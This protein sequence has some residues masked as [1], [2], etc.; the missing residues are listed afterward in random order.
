MIFEQTTDGAVDVITHYTVYYCLKLKMRVV[1]S[2]LECLYY[3]L[4]T[5][6]VHQQATQRAA[7][8][9]QAVP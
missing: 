4:L 5:A 9:R 8:D 6:H 1:G 7:T 3:G 2:S